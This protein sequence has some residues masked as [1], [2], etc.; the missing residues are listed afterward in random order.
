MN[1]KQ[2]ANVDSMY[3]DLDTGQ[4]VP[5]HDY[6]HRVIGKLGLENIKPY[7]PYDIKYLK[8]KL[9]EDIHLNNTNLTEWDCA[10]GYVSYI[11]MTT[12]TKEYHKRPQ[13]GLG[14]LFVRNGITCSSPSEGVCVL[15]EAARI[16]C[17]YNHEF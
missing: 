8:E 1:L 13:G 15:K 9:K 10:A 14:N 2:F 6:M 3:R 4:E 17:G 12:K 11:N 7:I 16:L 5:W